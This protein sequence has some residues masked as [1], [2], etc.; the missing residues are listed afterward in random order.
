MSVRERPQSLGTEARISIFD[1]LIAIVGGVKD[2]KDSVNIGVELYFNL[3]MSKL[4]PRVSRD[5]A[6]VFSTGA[7][8]SF[9]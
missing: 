1:S 9:Q 2:Y 3:K 6:I 5:S 4:I 8:S 7:P